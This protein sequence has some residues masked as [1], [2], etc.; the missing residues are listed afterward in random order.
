MKKTLLA[1]VAAAAC[2]PARADDYVLDRQTGTVSIE[3]RVETLEKEVAD[4]KKLLTVQT[5]QIP[6]PGVKADQ[7]P[8][9]CRD[10]GCTAALAQK[11]TAPAGL[12]CVSGVCSVPSAR[13]QS[14]PAGGSVFY[15]PAAADGFTSGGACVGGSCS[16]P[17]AGR[18][19]IFGRR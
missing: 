15:A 14:V 6:A 17:A 4:L 19:R 3:K 12:V 9:G 13:V 16:A 5:A 7:N 10:C 18:F 2:Q 11:A 1:L 8:A